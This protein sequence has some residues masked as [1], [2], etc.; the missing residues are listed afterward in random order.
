MKYDKARWK[1]N[2]DYMLD[3]QV[4]AIDKYKLIDNIIII[5][6]NYK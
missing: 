2:P 3:T 6:L 4:I 1:V 5:I